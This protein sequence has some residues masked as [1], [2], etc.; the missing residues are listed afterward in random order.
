MFRRFFEN[1]GDRAS[2]QAGGDPA[3]IES[4]GSDIEDEDLEQRTKPGDEAL[5]AERSP[6]EP[7][8]L[9]IRKPSFLKL[10]V[11]MLFASYFLLS[12]YHAPL[13][14]RLAKLLVV[15]HQLEQADLVVCLAG[16]PI[17][18]G[19]A[20]AEVYNNGLAPLVFYAREELPD[21]SDFLRAQK[22]HFPEDRD[23][24]IQMLEE[25][26]V[27]RSACLSSERL[28]GST[29]EEALIV[30][31]VVQDRGFKTVIVVT[32]PTHTRRAWWTYR[33]VFENQSVDVRMLPSSFSS[34]KTDD[35]WKSRQYLREVI[36]EYQKLIYY[37]LKHLW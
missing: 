14:A 32:S 1:P 35:W 36:V 25:L 31:S 8:G 28:A 24:A 10:F 34:F 26:G 33:K 18:R 4:T 11:F 16:Q 9:R 21:G 19:L 30:R 3:W 29:Y 6:I 13:L 17:E 23:L 27:P 2:R 22:V 5:K 12:Y 7:E 20:A 37:A 15:E